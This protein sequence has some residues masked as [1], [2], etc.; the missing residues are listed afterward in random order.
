MFL[1]LSNVHCND[2]EA[3]THLWIVDSDQVK[4]SEMGICI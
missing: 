3:E 2:T 1:A 4:D